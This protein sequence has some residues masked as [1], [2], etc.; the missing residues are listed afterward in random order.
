MESRMSLAETS[1]IC[2]CIM[3]PTNING[4]LDRKRGKNAKKPTLLDEI[5]LNS[6]DKLVISNPK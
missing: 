5:F 6:G 1:L 4:P 3:L 2:I